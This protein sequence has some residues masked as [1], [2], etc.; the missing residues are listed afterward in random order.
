MEKLF[1]EKERTTQRYSSNLENAYKFYDQTAKPE[2]IEVRE[3]LNEWFLRYP[4]S[5]KYSLKRDFQSQFDA[6]FFELFIHE[7]FF[8]Q[9][10]VLTPHPVVPNSS[11]NPDF[12]AKK[13]KVEMYLEAKVA[14]DKSNEERTLEN[15][16]GAIYDEL[17]KLESPDYWIDIKEIIFTSNKQAKLSKIKVV[18]QKWLDESHAKSEI[19]YNDCDDFGEEF[20]TYKDDDIKISLTL[21]PSSIEKDHPIASYLG[22]SYTGGCEQALSNAI[23]EKSAKYGNLDR[24]YIVC[25]N[26]TGDRHPYQDEI[27]NTLFGL[28]RL[29]GENYMGES[30]SQSPEMDGVLMNSMGPTFRQVSAFFI[31]RVFASNLHVANHWLIEHPNAKLRLSFDH[32]DLTSN[33]LSPTEIKTVSKKSIKQVLFPG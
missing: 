30:A 1:D 8:Q 7:L 12:L 33:R 14:T 4:D 2:F 16:Q 5:A 21:F 22:S 10:F 11:K 15:R 6:A 29:L 28:R 26:L 18:I 31:T 9:G 32:L 27:Y 20:Y 19:T 25:I 23:R 3:M 17:Q 24:P 13:G